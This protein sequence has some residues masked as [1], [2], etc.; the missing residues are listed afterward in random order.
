[1]CVQLDCAGSVVDR[2][3]DRIVSCL[4]DAP[5]LRLAG[6]VDRAHSRHGAASL[7][8]GIASVLA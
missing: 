8:A 7:R 1:M 6:P 5:H 4:C 3:A 2:T